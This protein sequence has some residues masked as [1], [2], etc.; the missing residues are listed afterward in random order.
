MIKRAVFRSLLFVCIWLIVVPALTQSEV[1]S[2]EPEVAQSEAPVAEPEIAQ[3]EAPGTEAEISQPEIVADESQFDVDLEGRKT[4]TIRY[5]L[6]HPIGLATSGLSPGQLTLDQT[7]TVDILGEA[8]SVLTIEA[9]YNDQLP[10]TMQS[11]A[12]YLDTEHLDGVLGDFTFGSVPDFTAYNKKMKGLQ[13]EYLIGDAVLTAVVSK[14]EGVSETVVFVGQTAHA[15]I[16]YSVRMNDESED[17]A[18]YRRNLNGLVAYPL[19]ALYAEDFSSIHFQFAASPSLRSV[20]SLYEVE[21]LFDAVAS[22]PQL[23]MKSQD[24]R[25]LDAGA[26]VLLL[27]RDP[28]FLI[29][30]RLRD[31]IDE[32]NEQFE[33]TGSEAKKYPFTAGTEYEL[34]FLSEVAPFAQLVVDDIVYPFGTAERQ[35]FYDLGHSDVR[36][37]TALI[38]VSTDGRT[39]ESV[40]SFRLPDYKVTLHEDAGVLECDFPSSFYTPSSSLRAAFDYAVSEGAFMLGLSLI[41]GSERVRLNSEPLVRD[42][43]YMIDYEVG[44]LFMLLELTDT[45]V[46][47]VDYELYAGGFGAAS[48]YASYFYGLTLDLP[49]SDSLTIRGNLLQLA[50]A[51]GTAADSERVRTMPNRHTIAGVQAD[52]SLED[53]TADVLV[54]YNQD[55]FPFDDN[56]RTHETNEL[57]TIAVG[58]GY[59]FFGHHAGVTVND[60]GNWQTYGPESGLSSQVVQAIGVGDGIIYLGTDAGLTLVHLDGA[61]PFDRAGN[62]TRY[63]V[64][65]GL[66]DPSVTAILVHDGTVWIGTQA[67]LVSMP[68]DGSEPFEHWTKLRSDD[69]DKLP[70]VTAFAATDD[71]LYIGTG[72][73]VYVYDVSED[74]LNLISGTDTY[75][76]NDLTLVNE[77]LYVASNR[78]LRGF[79]NGSGMGWLLLGQ[80]VYSVAH[81]NDTLYY[82]LGTGVVAQRSGESSEKLAGWRVS[83]MERA[84]DGVW[85][86]THASETYEMTVWLVSEGE[87]AFPELTT[88]I[89]GVDPYAFIDSSA[90]EHTVTG[91]VARAAF[92]HNADDY[93]LSGVVESHPPTFRS[94]G[95]FRRADSTGWTLS[96]DFSLG[97]QGHLRVDHDYR[98]TDQLGETPRDRMGNGL[99][100]EWSFGDGP[101]WMAAIQHVRTNETDTLGTE[102]TGE[103]T[104]SFSVHESFFRDALDLQLS[105]DRYNSTSDRWDEQWQRETLSL[106][107][108]WQFYRTLSTSGSWSRPIRRAE[109]DLSGSEHLNWNW[110]WSTSLSFADLDVEYSADWSRILFEEAGDLAHNAEMR[111]DVESFTLYGW[112]VAP[113]LKLEGEHESTATDLHAEFIVRSEIEVLT[114][115]TA[116]RGH[117][118][119]LGRPV[120]NRKGELSLNAKYSGFTDLDVSLTYTGSRGAAVKADESVASS[121]DSLT[122]RLVWSPE[123]GPRDELSFSLRINETETSRQVTATIDNGFTANLSSTLVSLL[124]WEAESHTEGYP[125]ADLRVDSKAEYRVGTSDPEL[126]FSTTGTVVVAMAPTWSVAFAA[127]YDMGH[128]SAIGF[129]NSFLFELTFAID[130]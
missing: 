30:E 101:E 116:V 95:S 126:S 43:D 98:L 22:E 125:I 96:G 110:D 55:R 85:I 56:E 70:P 4:W 58:E 44:M 89:S 113:D 9:H 80:P 104:A 40:A 54:G 73:G 79:R 105:W 11:L 3:P 130:F 114:L 74:R 52:I 86:G 2:T 36:A 100:L 1:P 20:F 123:S 68:D 99:S 71:I 16:E 33:L 6:G 60:D 93:T 42:V 124:G 103:L 50:D 26:Q 117:L 10:E 7:L 41:P 108:D 128:K 53:F 81:A 37:N 67:G 94:I 8:L 122:G 111:L 39:F 84:D 62:W 76:V 31:L 129:Y 107:F 72:G 120:F 97:R 46:L 66:P 5:G 78:G 49:I 61:S 119:E 65:D 87:Q 57:N 109:D 35:R 75:A 63:F 102:S 77:T 12:L 91:W 69:F 118:T 64:D 51:A 115:R 38:E 82:G 90:S 24:Y 106:S 28:V 15:E 25:V 59:V 19:E 47:E 34:S 23:E 127:T 17:V 21:F 32:Y 48:D 92:R 13:L 112:D 83:A 29:R 14:T 121:G 18:P 45:D 88:G 27:Q